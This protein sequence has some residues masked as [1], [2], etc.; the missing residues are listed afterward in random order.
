[1]A[2]TTALAAR[3]GYAVALSVG[4]VIALALIVMIFRMR[5]VGVQTAPEPVQEG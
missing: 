5:A 4:L 2:A 3:V 1:M